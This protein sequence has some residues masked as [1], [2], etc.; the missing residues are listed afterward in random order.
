MLFELIGIIDGIT[1]V[2]QILVILNADHDGNG[3]TDFSNNF[4]GL[5]IRFISSTVSQ[6]TRP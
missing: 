3:V 1:C 4:G 6:N 5:C 2:R